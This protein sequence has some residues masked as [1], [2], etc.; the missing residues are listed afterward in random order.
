LMDDCLFCKIVKEEI[1]TNFLYQDEDFVAFKDI[2][3]KAP[4][5]ILI[6]TRKHLPSLNEAGEE[7]QALLGKGLL[8]AREIA[9]KEGILEGGYRIGINVGQ[10]AGQEVFHLHIHLLGGW[11][12]KKATD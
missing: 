9:K 3:P 10:G 2:N 8:V 4:V 1:P 6:V 12:N 5:H 11:K 7:D